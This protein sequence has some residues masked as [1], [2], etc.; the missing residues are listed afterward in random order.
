MACRS[1]QYV[2]FISANWRLSALL[3]QTFIKA[4]LGI[5][6]LQAPNQLGV[7]THLRGAEVQRLNGDC[8]VDFDLPNAVQVSNNLGGRGPS[9]GEESIHFR[10]IGTNA[11]GRPLDLRIVASDAYQAE[12]TSKN[13]FQ[14]NIGNIN[15][16]PSNQGVE[17]QVEFLF[18]DNK[19]PAVL[20]EF[21]WMFLDIDQS[22]NV[23]EVITV[24]GYDH[25]D[26]V[27]DAEYGV[28]E[29]DNNVTFYSTM[30]GSKC[31]NPQ[32]GHHLTVVDCNGTKVDQKKRSVVLWFKDTSKFNVTFTTPYKS[33]KA[34]TTGRNIMFTSFETEECEREH[35]VQ[36]I[37]PTSEPTPARTT[38]T[39]GGVLFYPDYWP[40]APAPEFPV[41]E[42]TPTALPC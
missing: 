11:R 25:W 2:Y 27:E 39:T 7:Q 4:Q 10:N 20:K 30:N 14:G 8:G 19:Q 23:K 41:G 42:T 31:D 24:E 5:A 38:T 34:P 28:I 26:K 33:A 9:G 16:N 40:M 12:E 36:T 35:A 13:G 3:V 32:D 17:F 1:F 22:N 18:T 6:L 21:G 15:F 37:A 29:G